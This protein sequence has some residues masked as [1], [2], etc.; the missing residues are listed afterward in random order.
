MESNEN[1]LYFSARIDTSRLQAD[2]EKASN[3]LSNIDKQASQEG[4]KIKELLSNVPVVTID[5]ATNAPT[6][7]S[8][9]AAAFEEIDRVTDTNKA[10]IRELT[11]EYDKLFTQKN[12]ASK[13]GTKD[14]YIAI[15][16]EMVAIKAN[17]K[18]REKVNKEAEVTADEL[19]KV[20]Q[21]LQKEAEAT[22]KASNKTQSLRT[23]I[24]ALS[25]QMAAFVAN[26]GD[27]K[28]AEYVKMTQELGRLMDI[29]G[30]IL[31]QG[32]VFANDEAQIAGVIKGI[33]GL[34][35]AFTAAQGAASLFVGNAKSPKP[36]VY[37]NG[38]ATSSTG[39]K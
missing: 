29:R 36:Y 15:Q 7:L 10:A 26:G 12:I 31:K 8:A 37:Y 19:L 28:S 34:T 6:T 30:D 3:I 21:R 27:E 35:G 33:G 38:F 23:Q 14:E 4:N 2:A 18:L 17:I 39:I 24:K 1:G 20:E 11:A 25:M 16:K 9:V 22:Q 5:I 32:S 13:A